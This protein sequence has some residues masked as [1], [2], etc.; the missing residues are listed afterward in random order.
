MITLNVNCVLILQQSGSYIWLSDPQ[1][2]DLNLQRI[3][4]AFHLCGN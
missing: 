1:G 2:S 3:R 4:L